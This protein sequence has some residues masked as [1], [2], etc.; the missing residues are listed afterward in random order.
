MSH[1]RVMEPHIVLFSESMASGSERAFLEGD[2][3]HMILVLSPDAFP[4]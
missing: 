4:Q 3:A 1:C 2:C